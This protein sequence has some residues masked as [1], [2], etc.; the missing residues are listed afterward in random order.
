LAQIHAE[1]TAS[2]QLQAKSQLRRIN[3]WTLVWLFMSIIPIVPYAVPLWDHALADTP[4]AYLIWIPIF[5]FGW[6][7]AA[8]RGIGRYKDDAELNGILGILVLLLTGAVL[9]AGTT[10]WSQIFVANDAGLLVWP[11]WS[12]GV[13]WLLFGIGITRRLLKPLAY[14]LLAWPPLY[15]VIVNK[16]NPILYGIANV[17]VKQVTHV[18][19]WIQTTST[20][21]SYLVDYHHTPLLVTVSSACSGGDSFLAMLILLPV[22]LV[23][24]KG[25]ITR[26]FMLIAVGAVLTIVMNLLR[27]ALLLVSAHVFGGRFT[28]GILHPIL[29]GLLFLVILAVLAAVG[30]MIGMHG[31]NM[32]FTGNLSVPGLG[33]GGMGLIAALTLTILLWPLYGWGEG[34]FRS[35]VTV[36]TN[37]LSQLM[38]NMPGYQ[39]TLLGVYHEA[40]ILGPGSYGTA[41]AYTND[42]GDYAMAELWWTYN[43]GALKSYAVNTCLLFHGNTISGRH[44]FLMEPG[45]PATSY[46]VLLTPNEIHGQRSLFEDVSYVYA[47][48]YQGRTAYIRAEFA[49]PVKYGVNANDSVVSQFTKSLP[50]LWT[51]QQAQQQLVSDLPKNSTIHLAQFHAFVKDFSQVTLKHSN[52]SQ[53]TQST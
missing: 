6:G 39:R 40:S 37:Q 36:T 23:A 2:N 31:Q 10:R 24:F 32:E 1:T 17:S 16:T 27:L 44:T 26:K 43:L 3:L 41:Y 48:K 13:A 35:P 8:L 45:I 47:V 15:T 18:I 49:T 9:F 42:K 50:A 29:G 28:F 4:Y 12:L 51:N 5:G 38:P 20:Y 14:V 22:I 7:A 30:K 53:G 34:S 21:G 52:G 25:S 19:P 33:R 46:A 11:F